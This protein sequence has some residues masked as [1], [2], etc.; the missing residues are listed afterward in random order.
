MRVKAGKLDEDPTAKA[1]QRLIFLIRDWEN[2]CHMPY[3]Y[4]GGQE[5][6]SSELN[7]KVSRN[8]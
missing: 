3:G 1:F 4:E 2:A 5:Y 6:L 7:V 8:N